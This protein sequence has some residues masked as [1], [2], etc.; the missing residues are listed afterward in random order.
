M[1]KGIIWAVPTAIALAAPAAAMD[2]NGF[3]AG[4]VAAYT[5]GTSESSYDSPDLINPVPVPFS[6]FDLDSEPSGGSI[7]VTLGYNAAMDGGLV[8]GVEGDLSA[9]FVGDTIYDDFA[10]YR[11]RPD[12]AID[13]ETDYSGTLRGRLGFA[14]EQFMPFVTAG[15]AFAHSTVTPT[16]YDVDPI[17]DEA[18]TVGW[19]AGAGIEVAAS[20]TVS[21]KGEYLYTDLGEHTWFE[22][23]LYSSTSHSTSHS[24]RLGVNFHFD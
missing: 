10:D 15:L 9:A 16:D 6:S 20:D 11:G 1:L 21:V 2:W 22:G 19:A 5:S 7:G 24:V 13:I 12:N 14:S 8:F 23:E 3:Y 18:T 17:S 4:T